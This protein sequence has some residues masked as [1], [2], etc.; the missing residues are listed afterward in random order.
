MN[1]AFLYRFL[2]SPFKTI[3][4]D[5]AYT[6]KYE[7]LAVL[8]LMGL[9]QGASMGGTFFIVMGFL[10]TFLGMFV[11]FLQSIVFDFTAQLLKH[12]GQS[13]KLYH[14]LS[15]AS[16]PLLVNIPLLLLK[17]ARFPLHF[18]VGIIAFSATILTM[19]LQIYV[20]RALYSMS[21]R[22][23]IFVYFILVIMLAGVVALLVAGTSVMS[24]LFLKG[25]F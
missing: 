12:P 3:R 23:A 16:S 8:F 6:P 9:S 13:V 15:L 5:V 10:F 14:W 20:I 24:I 7:G 17:A 4:E 25:L 11:V 22:R 21:A 1:T 18:G 19:I 2:T